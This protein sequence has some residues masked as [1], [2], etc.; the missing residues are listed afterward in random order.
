MKTSGERGDAVF[1][2]MTASGAG[3]YSPTAAGSQPGRTV[4]ASWAAYLSWAALK[5]A[6]QDG[7]R[8][9]SNGK[10]RL[11]PGA[12]REEGGGAKGESGSHFV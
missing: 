5:G 10:M 11:S 9:R 12:R 2:S 7:G 4:A 3:A 1:S 8:R 6:A